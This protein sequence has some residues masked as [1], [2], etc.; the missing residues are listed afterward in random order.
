MVDP[1]IQAL[2]WENLR[3]FLNSNF[4]AALAGALAGALTAQHIAD[5]GK[6]REETLLELR[7]TNAAIMV[8]FI[9]CNAGI[10]LKKQLVKDIHDRYKAKLKELAALKERRARGEAVGVF[11][12]QA[13]LRTVQ[14]PIVPIDVLRTQMYE[15]V[16]VT[17]RPLALAAALIGSVEALTEILKKRTDL[18]ER[19]R[20]LGEDNPHLSA[21]YLGQPYGPGH[22][23]E[24]FPDTVD[25][26]YR[27]TDDM[28]FFSELLTSDLMAHGKRVLESYGKRVKIKDRKVSSVDFTAA[29]SEGW[30]PG[31]AEYTDWTKGFPNTAQQNAPTDRP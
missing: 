22:V 18:I 21:M 28:I 23:S 12:V 2:T 19:F 11:E 10:A 8:A 29:R 6:K 7:S 20:V 13:D 4:T 14:M 16:S 30:I 3:D 31:P 9:F 15:K 27:L 26:M 17:G 1:I 5:R 24:E 25:A